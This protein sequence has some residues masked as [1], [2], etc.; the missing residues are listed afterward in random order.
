MTTTAAPLLIEKAPPQSRFDRF[1]L[2]ILAGVVAAFLIVAALPFSA[3]RFGDLDFHR[4]A[5]AVALTVKGLKEWRTVSIL[6]APSPVFY[7]AVPYTLLSVNASEDTYWAAAFL[8]NAAWMAVAVLLLRRAAALLGGPAAGKAA[9]A[10]AFLVPFWVYYS[11]GIN[12][13]PP[14]FLGA[15]VTAWSWAHCIKKNRVGWMLLLWA[16]LT[17][18]VLAKPGVVL[19]AGIA[20]P[21]AVL[22]WRSGQKQIAKLTAAVLVLLVVTSI[23]SSR[24]MEYRWG[25]P[26]MNPQTKYLVWDLFFGSFQFRT[27]PWDWRFWDNTTREGSADYQSFSDTYAQIERESDRSQVPLSEA[28]LKWVKQDFREHPFVHLKMAAVRALFMQWMQISSV[29]PPAFHLG[30]LR[31]RAGYW[32]FHLGVNFFNLLLLLLS[33]LFLIRRREEA[34]AL[35]LLWAPW[36]ALLAFHSAIYAEPRFVFPG[37]PGLMI[38]SALCLVGRRGSLWRQRI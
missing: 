8:W 14:A 30:L 2:L 16:G 21:V 22:L 26:T 27:E 33:G 19:A 1:D 38:L 31:G 4:E 28:E 36:V 18:L 10:L 9:V 7:Y 17:V 6:R 5:K 20:A 35:W 32:L 12:G 25:H 3:K 15:T 24:Y 23:A 37:Q 13:E 34:L 11:Y 29:E